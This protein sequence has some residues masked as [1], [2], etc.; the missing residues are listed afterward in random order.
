MLKQG[1]TIEEVDALTGQAIGWPR[2]GTFR[3][4]DLVGID[5]LAHVAANFPQGVTQSGFSPVLEEIVKRG[6][7][8]DKAGQG[9]YKKSRGAD[10]KDER[11]VLDPATFEY[12]PA[13]KAALPALEMAKNAATLPERLRLLLANDPAK[14]KAAAF[15]WP[16]LAS[17]WNFAA[18]RIGE[19][20]G[21]AASIDQAMRAGF[22]WEMGP[23]EMWDAA[24]VG[25]TVERMK[26]L[27][28][29][30]SERVEALLA[31]GQTAGM[32][33]MGGS[34][35]SRRRESW[36]RLRPFR[37]T[38]GLRISGGRM[39]WSAPN[40][41]ASLVDLGDGIGCIELHSLKN[42]IGGDVLALISAVL[43]P[44]SDAVRDFAGF[45][46]TGDRDNF[47]VGANLMQLLLVA[48]EGE[49]EEVAAVING[50]QQMTAAI[51]FCPRPVVVAPFGM[52][53]GGGAEIC[54]HGARR[55]AHA[56]TYIGLVEAGVGL[57]PA[58]GGTK[59]MLLRAVDQA[60]ALASARPA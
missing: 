29:P 19:V 49:W 40:A 8:G 51:K 5:I 25:S 21:D 58:G 3:L 56:E 16:F 48:Q 39:G 46:I 59:E 20:A 2:T 38:R 10:G 7:L 30:V 6:W 32:R 45:V 50:F 47:S 23:F 22:N 17:L 35:F 31:A 12:R 57:I 37:G 11:L 42:A 4:A 43:N 53:F 44:D 9:F 27:G 55:Q 14:D 26:A 34:V 41:G 24:G 36:S 15:L 1:L 28:L 18:E 52:T 33:A 60:A 13:A 54:L